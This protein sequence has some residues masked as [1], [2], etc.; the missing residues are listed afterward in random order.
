LLD[1]GVIQIGIGVQVEQANLRDLLNRYKDRP[2]S[3]ADACLVRLSELHKDLTVFTLDSDF[4]IYRRF[5]NKVIPML[6]PS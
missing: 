1:R 6:I 4:H 2:M 3:L 5:G